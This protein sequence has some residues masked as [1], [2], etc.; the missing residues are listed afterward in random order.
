MEMWFEKYR[1]QTLEDYVC[2]DR[3]KSI[4]SNTLKQQTHLLLHGSAGSGKT[5]LC[6]ILMNEVGHKSDVM[7]INASSENNVDFVR[8]KIQSFFY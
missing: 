3:I 5:T 6:K 2:D 7:S 4:I 8:N 1:P